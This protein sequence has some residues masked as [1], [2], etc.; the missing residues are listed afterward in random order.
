MKKISILNNFLVLLGREGVEKILSVLL[1][2]LVLIVLPLGQLPSEALQ[3]SIPQA[4]TFLQTMIAGLYLHD[5]FVAL[6]VSIWMATKL[7]SSHVSQIK[8][9]M[10]K[11]RWL[12]SACALI[13]FGFLRSVFADGSVLPLFYALRIIAYVSF[14]LIVARQLSDRTSFVQVIVLSLTSMM[15]L[16]ALQYLLLPDVRYLSALGW[17]DHYYRA[18]GTSLDPNF[19]GSFAI[20]SLWLMLGYRHLFSRFFTFFT[21]LLSVGVLTATFS[22]ASYLALFVSGA[23]ILWRLRNSLPKVVLTASL[24]VVACGVL[25]I[26]LLLPK[27]GGEGVNLLRTTSIVARLDNS[28]SPILNMSSVEL[29][30]GRGFYRSLHNSADPWVPDNLIVLII[31]GTGVLGII[32]VIQLWR[33]YGHY[34]KSNIWLGTIW[35]AVLTHAQFNNTLLEPF[36]LLYLGLITAVMLQKP[37]SRIS[38]R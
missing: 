9:F 29:I 33:L 20:M 2:I 13:L 32:V 12:V 11:H 26:F 30:F 25:V 31:T 34:F 19:T 18:V 4:H 27:P 37:S 14:A 15:Y 36:H 24:A 38:A 35:V 3:L 7:N 28:I 8:Q 22:R 10:T 1:V 5:L 16:A 17:D 21:L 6:F 23:Y